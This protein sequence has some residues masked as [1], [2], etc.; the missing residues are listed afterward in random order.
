MCVIRPKF[1]ASAK[2]EGLD[3]FIIRKESDPGYLEMVNLVGMKSLGL[4]S[5]V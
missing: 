3:D 5:Y 1:F 4:T 2:H